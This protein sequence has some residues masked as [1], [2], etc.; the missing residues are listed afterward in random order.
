MSGRCRLST[1]HPLI[2]FA[3]D[4]FSLVSEVG[5][6]RFRSRLPGVSCSRGRQPS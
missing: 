3:S 2:A 5:V 1:L 4:P 6:Q